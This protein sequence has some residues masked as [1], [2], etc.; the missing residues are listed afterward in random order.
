M[1]FRACK[2]WFQRFNL[3]RPTILGGGEHGGVGVLGEV[4]RE[5]RVVGAGA[6]VGARGAR[7]GGG[8]DAQK[9]PARRAWRILLA[10][11]SSTLKTL[12]G[13]GI[14]WS[15]PRGGPNGRLGWQSK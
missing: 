13:S 8:G 6:A 3:H 9:I 15:V 12:E 10:T 11:S 4:K 7:G 5:P 14:D 2:R 1:S